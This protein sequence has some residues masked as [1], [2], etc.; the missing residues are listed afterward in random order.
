[1]NLLQKKVEVTLNR[2]FVKEL[3]QEE[4]TFYEYSCRPNPLPDLGEEQR[5]LSKICN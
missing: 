4:L 3:T 5:A 1:M 2:F